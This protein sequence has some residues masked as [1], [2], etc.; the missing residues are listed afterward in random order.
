MNIDSKLKQQIEDA[1][2]DYI[3]NIYKTHI[4]KSF[5]NANENMSKI[6]HEIMMLRGMTGLKTRHFYNNMLTM[7]GA[8]YL[9]IGS[10]T[11]S[12]VCSAM[13]GNNAIVLCMD[14]WS[15][16]GIPKEEFVNNFNKFKGN[17]EAIFI[18]RDC[19]KIDISSFPKFNIFLYDA[20]HSYDN[21]YK[22]LFHYYS[23]LDDVFIY[24][25]DDWNWPDVRKGTMDSIAKLNLN[26]IY[27]KE[28]RLTFDDSYT[29]EPMRTTSYWN[30]IYVAILQK[31]N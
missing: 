3:V 8:R 21:H 23:C 16:S 4:K 6:N 28:I 9:E 14:N 29:K 24:I 7:S 20:E 26:I 13:Y 22:A 18:E 10:S 27:E 15:E 17:N 25:V 12:A 11:G 2:T 31:T 19:F 30:G 5:E 1:H